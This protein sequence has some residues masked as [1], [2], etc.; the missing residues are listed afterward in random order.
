LKEKS[1]VVERGKVEKKAKKVKWEGPCCFGACELQKCSRFHERGKTELSI[2][3][4]KTMVIPFPKLTCSFISLL[5]FN[6]FAYFW[7]Y[8]QSVFSSIVVSEAN[9]SNTPIS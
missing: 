4:T 3:F 9:Y 6:P 2:T 8:F 1:G 7:E 5:L